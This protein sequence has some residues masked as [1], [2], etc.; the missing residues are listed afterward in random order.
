MLLIHGYN[1]CKGNM[2]R[3]AEILQDYFYLVII[4][5]PGMNLSHKPKQTPFKC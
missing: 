5:L 4:D 3:I 1:A 2:F